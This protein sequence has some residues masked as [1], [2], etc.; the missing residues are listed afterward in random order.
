M[1]IAKS[2][3]T[4]CH[5]MTN[6]KIAKIPLHYKIVNDRPAP[7]VAEPWQ[8]VLRPCAVLC[9]RLLPSHDRRT[10]GARPALIV[11]QPS[12]NISQPSVSVSHPSPIIRQPSHNRTT[13]VSDRTGAQPWEFSPAQSRFCKCNK[14]HGCATVVIENRFNVKGAL[15]R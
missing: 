6:V 4:C 10:T 3:A 2:C 8:S 9:S 7:S 1:A 13:T 12:P 14:C 15:S 5:Q 11:P